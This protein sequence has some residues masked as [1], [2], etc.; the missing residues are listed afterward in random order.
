MAT[1]NNSIYIT[2][3]LPLANDER[4]NSAERIIEQIRQ[5]RIN[6]G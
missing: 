2:M 6:V 5:E 1:I 3:R 4:W